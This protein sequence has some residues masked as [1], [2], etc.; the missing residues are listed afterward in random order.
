MTDIST[1]KFQKQLNGGLCSLVLLGLLEQS[2]E[3][4]YG[5]DIAKRLAKSPEGKSIFKEGTLYPVLRSLAAA[6]LLTSRIVLS[7]AGPPRRYYGITDQG[8]ATL[9]EWKLMW[10]G[11]RRFV[12]GFIASDQPPG[13]TAPPSA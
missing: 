10:T 13:F 9:R 8:R 1:A 7:Y 6:R 3:D 12:D 2:G 5:Y 11:T 4:L